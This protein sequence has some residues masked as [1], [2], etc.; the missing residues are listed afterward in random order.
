MNPQRV[1]RYLAQLHR[2][3][4]EAA[5]IAALLA[6]SDHPKNLHPDEVRRSENLFAFSGDIRI[7]RS[8][9]AAVNARSLPF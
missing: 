5:L 1:C 3:R 9:Q 7:L 2:A 4:L 6:F 8:F